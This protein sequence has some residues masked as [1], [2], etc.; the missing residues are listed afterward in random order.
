MQCKGSRGTPGGT[1]TPNLLIH[2]QESLKSEPKHGIEKA[3]K[4]P[5]R[6]LDEAKTPWRRYLGSAFVMIG[7]GITTYINTIGIG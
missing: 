7:L 6:F 3:V 1:R 4:P 2:T 5:R